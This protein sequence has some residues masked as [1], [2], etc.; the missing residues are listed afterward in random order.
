VNYIWKPSLFLFMAC[1]ALGQATQ[2]TTSKAADEAAVQKV[3]E[4]FTIAMDHADV[5]ALDRL[6]SVDYVWVNIG[7]RVLTKQQRLDLDRTGKMKTESYAVD[8]QMIRMYGTT[9]IVIYRS[10]V[11][12]QYSGKD[13][14][15]QRRVTTVLLK[16]DGHWQIVSQQ[17]TEI[18]HPPV[19]Q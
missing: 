8:E 7:G 2:N 14:P 6:W 9:A 15:P 10:T 13:V 16:Q 5:A 12:G 19:A 17:S 4:E 1:L 11:K 3:M 18:Y